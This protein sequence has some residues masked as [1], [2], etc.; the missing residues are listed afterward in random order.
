VVT[1]LAFAAAVAGSLAVPAAAAAP[2][3]APREAPAAPAAS[4]APAASE[5]AGPEAGPGLGECAAGELCLWAKP[6][7][8]GK[9]H[10]YE[11]SGVRMGSCQRLPRGADA[12]SLANR[13]GRPVT[14]YESGECAETR[15]FHTH[16]SG[17]W[18]PEGAYKVRAF[19]VWER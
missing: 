13:T 17:S 4:P 8:K 11:R 5:A 6:R 10:T 7:F 16:P 2:S 3:A 12:G 1:G 14:V 9:R 19:K 18:T 15:E